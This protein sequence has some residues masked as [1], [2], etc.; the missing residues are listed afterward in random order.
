MWKEC[1]QIEFR[2]PLII[3]WKGKE[4]H[5]GPVDEDRMSLAANLICKRCQLW[6]GNITKKEREIIIT[7]KKRNLQWLS[8]IMIGDRYH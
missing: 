7:T 5:E 6:Q 2:K 4:V 1:K 3:D 8:Q